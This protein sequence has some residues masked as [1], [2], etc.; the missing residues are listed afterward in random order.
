MEKIVMVL[1]R[2]EI[3]IT[4]I[5]NKEVIREDSILS[6]PCTR[7]IAEEVH[8]AFETAL[9]IVQEKRSGDFR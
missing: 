7:E 5:K 9:K 2:V 8:T 4:H 6:K 3:S 1:Y